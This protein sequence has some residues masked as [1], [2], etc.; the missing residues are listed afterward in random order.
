MSSLTDSRVAISGQPHRYQPGYQALPL[1]E[2][3][4]LTID[5]Q[6]IQPGAT[7]VEVPVGV[8][9]T[10]TLVGIKPFKGIMARL[11]GGN[12]GIDTSTVFAFFEGET[13]LKPNEYCDPDV[14][15]V[16]CQRRT[17]QD[18]TES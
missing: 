9:L 14:S 13:N 6:V 2:N 17:A 3:F 16:H 4:D 18:I 7:D 11:D 1:G 15:R 5:D 10:V 12:D 8:P